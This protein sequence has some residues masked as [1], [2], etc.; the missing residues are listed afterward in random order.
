[1]INVIREGTTVEVTEESLVTI[2]SSSEVK[3]NKNISDIYYVRLILN[4]AVKELT[5]KQLNLKRLKGIK[6]L[7][8]KTSQDKITD[9]AVEAF[10][11]TDKDVEAVAL[12]VINLQFKVDN[13]TAL[14]SSIII[15]NEYIRELYMP[16][17]PN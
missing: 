9:K 15:K 4:E 8:Y 5:E 7:F 14:V 1:M 13:L 12:E 11:H 10:C 2:S 16:V 6:F 3:V 17:H